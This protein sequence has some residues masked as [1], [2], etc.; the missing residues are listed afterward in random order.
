MKHGKYP[1][2]DINASDCHIKGR[3]IVAPH[4]TLSDG[5]VKFITIAD[6]SSLMASRI[7][8]N[9]LTVSY[10]NI[11][12]NNITTSTLSTRG[13]PTCG[14]SCFINNHC[15]SLV[16]ATLIIHNRVMHR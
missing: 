5:Y 6:S 4:N 1:M 3:T 8:G 12:N 7:I 9:D 14:N 10:F 2:N 13:T 15:D 11:V 16:T